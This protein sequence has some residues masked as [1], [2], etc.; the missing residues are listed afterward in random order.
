MLWERA[1][2]VTGKESPVRTVN[3]PDVM[4]QKQQPMRKVSWIQTPN[5]RWRSRETDDDR[6]VHPHLTGNPAGRVKQ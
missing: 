5:N 3:N 6:G 4:Q 1:G 2:P